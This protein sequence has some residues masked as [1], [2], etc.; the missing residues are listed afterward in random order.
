ME[1]FETMSDGI[2]DGETAEPDNVNEEDAGVKDGEP[3]D[4]GNKKENSEYAAA[5]SKAESSEREFKNKVE[6]LY[7][8]R[9]FNSFEEFEESLN[10]EEEEKVNKKFVDVFGSTA[11]EV[12]PLIDSVVSRKMLDEAKRIEENENS[13][14]AFY[15]ELDKIK[16]I[17][18]EIK[19]FEDVMKMPTFEKFDSIYQNGGKS[20][21]EA[22]ILANYEDISRKARQDAMNKINSKNHMAGTG[23]SASADTD[24]NI[25]DDVMK[26][27]R[28][29]FPKKT[30]SEIRKHYSRYHK[31]GNKNV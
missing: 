26:M 20:L 18:P 23:G 27:Y 19:S 29:M 4:L 2:K 16:K 13:K 14:R 8:T 21:S 24:V 9:G 7:K 22:Y 17:N 5:R 3:A 30:E 1:D 6:R 11:D 28:K 25:P 15:G 12:R 10:R 31:G